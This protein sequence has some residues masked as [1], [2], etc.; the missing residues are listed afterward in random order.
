MKTTPEKLLL[1]IKEAAR[2]LSVSDRTVW[3]LTNKGLLPV[4]RIGS[5]TLYS[6]ESLRR[7]ISEAERAESEV[8][9]D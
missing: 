3:T 9:N 2:M 6:V 8:A 5:R 1:S 4:T 7:F